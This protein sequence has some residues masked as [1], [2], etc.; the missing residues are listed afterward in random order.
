[1]RSDDAVTPSGTPDE[2]E[3]SAEAAPESSTDAASW[4]PLRS[5]Y[6]VAALL[7]LV[8]VVAASMWAMLSIAATDSAGR[9]FERSDV[10]GDLT[11]DLHPGTWNIYL[12]GPASIDAIKVT[13]ADGTPVAVNTAELDGAT[14]NH[15]G[16][17][18]EQIASFEIPLGGTASQMQIAVT[19]I[20]Q[21]PDTTFAVGAA[22][23]VGDLGVQTWGMVALLVVNI[24]AA[25]A[26]VI[27]PIVRRR[28]HVR[29][30]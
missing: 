13:D 3:T 19:G 24:G 27:T 25:V 9:S 18:T 12:E 16:F 20:A 14:Y 1:M 7:I 11:L 2:A 22:D 23:D 6:L 10:P 28:R 15:G 26:I 29:A 17:R 21:D 8:A 30:R 5:R 4:R